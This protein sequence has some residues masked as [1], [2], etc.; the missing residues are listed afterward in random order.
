MT[1]AVDGNAA[2]FGEW[3]IVEMLGHRRLAG[4]LR[5]VQIA[6]QGFLRL[7]IPDAD[8]DPGRT[9]YLAPGSIYALHPVSEATA[10]AA[11]KAWR[12]EPI[13]RWEL[14]EITTADAVYPNPPI[15][16]GSDDYE[17]F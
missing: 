7:D 2:P 1:A 3:S 6:G 9:Q 10:R 15:D 11:A 5:E 17:P 12:P 13:S 8:D 14:K 16:A 4:Y